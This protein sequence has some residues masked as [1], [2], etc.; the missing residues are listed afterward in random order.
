MQCSKEY[1]A[2]R[3]AERLGKYVDNWINIQKTHG[4]TE[5]PS[6]PDAHI[7][8]KQ[9]ADKRNKADDSTDNKDKAEKT[10]R[11]KTKQQADKT[12]KTDEGTE[13]R[14]R[15]EKTEHN[16]GVHQ[17]GRRAHKK[18]AWKCHVDIMYV[19]TFTHMRT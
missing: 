15:T 3:V 13:H 16:T 17:G 8:Q 12:N 10:K 2:A 19:H 18:W 9:Q 14:E 4:V 6:H 11:S 5:T 1:R 7:K